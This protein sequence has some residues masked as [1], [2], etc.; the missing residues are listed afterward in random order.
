M[1]SQLQVDAASVSFLRCSVVKG[2]MNVTALERVDTVGTDAE[3]ILARATHVNE[4][5]PPNQSN[6]TRITHLE[7]LNN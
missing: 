5:M 4:T 7:L 1:F 3:L 2:G 6:T